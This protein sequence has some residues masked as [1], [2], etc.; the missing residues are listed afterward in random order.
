M[1]FRLDR[2]PRP[3]C[4][5][6]RVVATL[7]VLV[8]GAL[9]AGC[10]DHMNDELSAA[11]A[12]HLSTPQKRHP[13]GT[14]RRLER[15]IVEVERPGARLAANQRADVAGFI[16]GYKTNGARRL[17]IS[18]PARASGHLSSRPALQDI[19]EIVTLSGLSAEM[20]EVRY[21]TAGRGDVIELAYEEPTA[22]APTCGD[23][24]K[25]AGKDKH[26]LPYNNFGC[27]TQRNLAKTMAHPRDLLISQPAAPRSSQKRSD[28]WEGYIDGQGK[29]RSSGVGTGSSS[30]ATT[31]K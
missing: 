22:V 16:Q 15:L 4:G 6:R 19:E 20:V 31:G 14:G 30:S 10:F 8:A 1:A 26:V 24:S 12:V 5:A 18:S 27:A 2:F 29:R 28:D 3:A 11:H 21:D 7:G 25:D 9:L 23:W 13:I 17:R